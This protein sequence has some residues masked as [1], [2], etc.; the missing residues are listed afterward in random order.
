MVNIKKQVP[1]ITQEQ[2]KEA[3]DQLMMNGLDDIDAEELEDVNG[4]GFNAVKEELNKPL[5]FN[6]MDQMKSKF[7]VCIQPKRPSVES[8]Q[9]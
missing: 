2:S 6:K 7:D 1:K 5:A 4:S 8:Y 3:L 9:K